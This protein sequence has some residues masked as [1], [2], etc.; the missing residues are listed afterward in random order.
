MRTK[1]S[2][3]SNIRGVEQTDLCC[4]GLQPSMR[5]NTMC[6][7]DSKASA[8]NLLFTGWRTGGGGR[9]SGAARP[10]KSPLKFLKSPYIEFFNEN[11]ENKDNQEERKLR[12]L[13]IS[14]L[15]D[16]LS[17]INYLTTVLSRLHFE[18]C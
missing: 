16:S 2:T 9:P 6:I 5:F 10:Q 8:S 12:L 15:L 17:Y 18:L 7:L 4:T 14:V 13:F 1:L 3:W 11:K